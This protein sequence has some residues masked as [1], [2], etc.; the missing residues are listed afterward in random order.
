MLRLE[1]VRESHLLRVSGRINAEDLAELKLQM[2]VR[3]S[4]VALELS[5]VTLVDSEAVCFLGLAEASGTELRNCPLFVREWI[6][7]A[8]H[9]PDERDRNRSAQVQQYSSNHRAQSQFDEK[10]K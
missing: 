4:P 9:Q 10:E 5:E 6:R 7:R 1:R 2:E 8:H 3:P